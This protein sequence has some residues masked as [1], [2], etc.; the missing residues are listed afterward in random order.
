MLVGLL[1]LPGHEQAQD[2]DQK[3]RPQQDPQDEPTTA[4]DGD[5]I[6]SGAEPSY[7]LGSPRILLSGTESPSPPSP[8]P[9]P[10]RRASGQYAPRL[11]KTAPKVRARMV[12]SWN[13]D[14][15]ST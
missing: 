14:Q 1:G 11:P 5:G 10:A 8:P 6:S 12:R 3:P 9:V 7:S 4:A 13:I 15:L 2:D